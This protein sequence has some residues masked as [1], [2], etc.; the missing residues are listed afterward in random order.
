MTKKDKPV[1]VLIS[2]V[3]QKTKTYIKLQLIIKILNGFSGEDIIIKI[4]P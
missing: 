4:Q 1:L 3:I 2:F